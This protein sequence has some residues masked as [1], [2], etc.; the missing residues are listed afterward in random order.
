MVIQK[1]SNYPR[2]S[3]ACLPASFALTFASIILVFATSRG[4]VTAAANPPE[5]IKI[6]NTSETL[7]V[8]YEC[9]TAYNSHGCGQH[10]SIINA[11]SMF[12]PVRVQVRLLKVCTQ[13]VLFL[14]VDSRKTA[15]H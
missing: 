13:S 3:P 1:L 9:H 10:C 5:Q 14:R 6:P 12:P 2:H 11:Y 4:V 8:E 7:L 15:L